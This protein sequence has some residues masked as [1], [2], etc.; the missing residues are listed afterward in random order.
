M[1]E[2]SDKKNSK[3]ISLPFKNA[4]ETKGRKRLS[5][6]F[7]GEYKFN[8]ALHQLFCQGQR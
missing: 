1:G 4:F 3:D 6:F 5:F 2:N 7:L 8:W